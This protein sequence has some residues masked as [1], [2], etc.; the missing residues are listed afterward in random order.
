M[1]R[2]YHVVYA[3]TRFSIDEF[4]NTVRGTVNP[5]INCL[6]TRVSHTHAWRLP[7]NRGKMLNGGPLP[8]GHT[9]HDVYLD[10]TEGTPYSAHFQVGP[11]LRI[12]Q[13]QYSP[14]QLG[15]GAARPGSSN[16][17]LMN[18]AGYIHLPETD[19]TETELA[20][21]HQQ[22]TGPRFRITQ[23][24]HSCAN[25]CKYL[26]CTDNQDEANVEVIWDGGLPFL[27]LSEDLGLGDEL[28][29]F[30]VPVVNDPKP[31]PDLVAAEVV[32]AAAAAE[33]AKKVV[34]ARAAEAKAGATARAAAYW[35]GSGA[36]DVVIKTEP[37]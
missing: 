7:L 15:V 30:R 34:A 1:P 23:L 5:T 24:D 2:S 33:E 37:V 14:G 9:F 26:Q 10:H 12:I 18:L 21:T 36:N 19:L 22:Q 25:I 17:I 31:D 8:E 20:C 6:R 4:P 28:V 35:A 29:C 3:S 11:L 13:S 32:A 16:E 27:K